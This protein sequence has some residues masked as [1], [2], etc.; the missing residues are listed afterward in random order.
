METE[1]LRI[2]QQRV[3]C[4]GAPACRCTSAVPRVGQQTSSF[5]IKESKRATIKHRCAPLTCCSTNQFFH[6][7]RKSTDRTAV[8]VLRAYL[9]ERRFSCSPGA[10]TR[11]DVC[12]YWRALVSSNGHRPLSSA[13]QLFPNWR[14]SE[15]QRCM[16]RVAR[17]SLN[18]RCLSCRSANLSVL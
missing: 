5:E 12:L 18:E 17:V 16:C 13:S 6:T 10:K 3:V 1:R 9:H 4:Y 8:F 11:H 15:D 7:W 14:G 2:E